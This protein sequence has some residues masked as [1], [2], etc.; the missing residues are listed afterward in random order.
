[1]YALVTTNAPRS[2]GDK[3]RILSSQQTDSSGECV[4]F[5]YHMFGVNAGV[6]RVMSHDL[7]TDVDSAPSWEQTGR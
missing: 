3:A 5:W 4:R 1:M 6:L 7:I 2:Q